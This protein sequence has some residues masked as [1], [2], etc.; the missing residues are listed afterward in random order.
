MQPIAIQS[1]CYR[2]FKTLDALIE[3]LK[4]TG[5]SAVELCGVHADFTNEAGYARI[6]ETF[7]AARIR[8]VAIGVE[9]LNGDAAND[10]PRLRFCRAAGVKNV[11][12]SFPPEA[13]FDGV[14]TIEK[15]AEKYDLKFGIH[16]HGGYDW[17]GN[18]TILKYLFS[19][20]GPRI[21]LHMDTAW[22]IDA[23]QNPVEWAEKFAD[24]LHGVHI[25]DFTYDRARQPS[26]VIISTGNLDLPVL[27]KTLKQINF[28][29]PLVIEYE[30]DEN[31]PVP[32]LSECVAKLRAL[33]L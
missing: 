18:A 13:M 5:V 11:S 19:K 25:K 29:G 31:N 27:V 10:E 21:G 7:A 24:R 33:G 14:K 28:D 3:Q 8:I 6:I 1:W 15:L 2:N 32:A 20:T 16:N 23:K 9:Y 22:A 12:I 30:G 26:D 4:A 17:L